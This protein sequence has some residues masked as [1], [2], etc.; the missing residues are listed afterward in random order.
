MIFVFDKL[1]HT[2]ATQGDIHHKRAMYLPNVA[3][4]VG[5]PGIVGHGGLFLDILHSDIPYK[6]ILT[7]DI[8][9]ETDLLYLIEPWPLFNGIK[10]HEGY[11]M[12]NHPNHWHAGVQFIPDKIIDL[13]KQKRLTILYH[14]P[15]YTWSSRVLIRNLEDILKQKSIPESQFKYISG[16]RDPDYYYWPSFEYSQQLTST[17][18]KYIKEVNLEKRGKKFTCLNR[19]DRIQRRFIAIKLWENDLIKDGYFSCSRLKHRYSGGFELSETLDKRTDLQ[20]Y[21]WNIPDSKWEEFLDQGPWTA[22]EL[23]WEEHN[24]HWHVEPQHYKNAYWNFVTETGIFGGTFL[25]EKTFKPIANL[26]PSVIIGS[27]GT[28]ELLH[29]LGYKTFGDYINESYDNI[30]DPVLR[31]KTATAEAIRLAKKSDNYHMLL[32][33]KIKPILEHNQKHFFRSKHRIEHF[34]KYTQGTDPSYNWLNDCKYD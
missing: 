24:H 20:D 3:A 12:I 22:D 34:V 5:M 15:E 1:L 7:D 31:V 29:D 10:E 17:W 21:D 11:G 33:R 2:V 8:T 18:S 30:D 13:A 16:I 19:L 4:G 25:S 14:I 9:N 32:M 26:Q 23:S 27:K 28:L 6:T